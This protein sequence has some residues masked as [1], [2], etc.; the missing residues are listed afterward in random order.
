MI[1]AAGAGPDPIPHKSLTSAK[2]VDAIQ[3][4]LQPEAKAAAQSIAASMSQEEG[5]RTAVNSFYANLPVS[6][7]SCDLLPNQPA[8]WE[9]QR[10][11]KLFKLSGVAA[12]IL[13]SRLKVDP[14]KLK[15]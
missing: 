1:A 13:V 14:T 5:V 4:C 9:Y 2:R 8:V 12:E 10:K 7:M 3:F 6:D 15:L 11:G